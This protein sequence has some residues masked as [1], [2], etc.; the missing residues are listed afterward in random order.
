M[1][2]LY[3]YYR[4]N[5]EEGEQNTSGSSTGTQPCSKSSTTDVNEAHFFQGQ[6][7]KNKKKFLHTDSVV[8]SKGQ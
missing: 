5:G 2:I 6:R 3:T 8:P 1:K 7:N 4:V